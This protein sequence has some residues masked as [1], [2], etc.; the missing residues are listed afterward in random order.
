MADH[1]PG[2]IGRA[3]EFWRLRIV[4]LDEAGVP[5][6]LWRDDILYRPARRE[7]VAEAEAYRVDAVSL[8]QPERV[9]PISAFPDADEAHEWTQQVAVDLRDMTRSQFEEAYLPDERDRS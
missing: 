3:D 6:L 4:R 1:V 5:D 7:G 8:D 2:A 9:V